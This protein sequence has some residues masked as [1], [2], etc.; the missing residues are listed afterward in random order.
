MLCYTQLGLIKTITHPQQPKISTTTDNEDQAMGINDKPYSEKRDFIRMKIG[1]PLNAKLAAATE[2]IEGL[3]LD[4]SGG[5]LQVEAK[6]SLAVGTE[7]EVEVSSDHGHNPTLK[8]RA[9]VVRS[10][11]N[12]AG[13]Y[14]LGLEIL[15]IIP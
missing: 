7:A 2:V 8:A 9:K 1:A 11:T 4:L 14:V 12:E 13:D 6:Q 3:C 5:G 15:Q 10:T